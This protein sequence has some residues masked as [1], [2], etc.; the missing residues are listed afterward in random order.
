MSNTTES[1]VERTVQLAGNTTFVVSLPKEWATEQGLEPGASMHLYPHHDRVVVA[2]ASLEA[3]ERERRIDA[4]SVEPEVVCHRIRVAY[5]AG[6]D[7]I[8]V[9]DADG[10]DRDVRR[11]LTRLFSRLIGVEILEETEDRIVATD[12]L[13]A[14]DVSLPQ[15]TAQIR[16][17]AMTM[18]ADAID[19]V[20]TDD[21][22]LARRVI[23]RD[24]DVDRLFA[25]VSRGFH[26]GLEDV[27]EIT[28]LDVD[29]WSAFHSYRT[30]RELERIAD[31]A[32]RIATVALGQ[33]SPPDDP[34]GSEMEAL[35]ADAR[36]VVELAL[37]GEA[38]EALSTCSRVLER[39]DRLDQQLCGECD[40]D[41]YRY[42]FVLESVRRIAELGVSLTES[43]I[44]TEDSDD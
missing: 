20:R 9:V 12:F 2:P 31:H 8:T 23:D 14:G 37:D 18:T 21:E 30:A 41:T 34:L 1:S 32:E 35:A 33:S 15:T 16:Q 44:E 4:G 10:F 11:R 43:T 17:H 26:R 38:D 6:T 39:T 25:F 29:R 22:A 3:S 28:S 24:D 40:P 19:A 42:G 7:R 5:A 13:N 36:D 27:Q